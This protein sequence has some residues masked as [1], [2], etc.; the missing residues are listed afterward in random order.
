MATGTAG[1]TA[2][3]YT[4]QQ[5]HYLRKGFTYADDG[6]TLTIGTIP[7]GSLVLKPISGVAITTAFNAGSTNVA[8]MGPSTDSGTD[9]WATD[10][11]LGTVGFVPIDEAVTNLVSVDTVVQIAVDLTGTA[12][13]TGAAEA[14]IC[15]IPDNDL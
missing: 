6:S 15:Y 2:R 12:A 9:L 5:V 7:A 8:D 10:L 13:T 4:T 14:I 3:Q 11:A 1:T